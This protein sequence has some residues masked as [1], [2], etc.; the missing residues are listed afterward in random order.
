[1]TTD[2]HL[3]SRGSR[4]PLGRRV[5]ARA[6]RVLNVPM[7]L[8]LGLPFP[9]PPGRRLRGRDYLARPEL[10]RDP[11]TVEQLLG[12]MT[13]ATPMVGRFVAVPRDPAGHYDHS[14]LELAIQHGFCIVRWHLD[15]DRVGSR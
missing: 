7:R 11:E 3:V 12:I 15:A 5:Q 14:R 4:R 8:I 10:V 13:A 2:S 6:F 9:T 1:M